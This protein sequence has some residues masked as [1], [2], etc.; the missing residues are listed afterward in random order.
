MIWRVCH[1][2]SLVALWFIFGTQ[3]QKSWAASPAAVQVIMPEW[4]PTLTRGGGGLYGELFKFILPPDKARYT[5]ETIKYDEA[6]RRLLYSNVDCAYPLTKRALEVSIQQGE[7]VDMIESMPVLISKSYLFSRPGSPLIRSVKHME[8][9]V[10]IQIA[11]ENYNH[12]FRGLD[13]QF[14]NVA[15]ASE[16]VR[17]LLAGRGDAM[18][19]SLPDILFSIADM[20]VPLPDFDPDFVVLEYENAVT[21]RESDRAAALIREFDERVRVTLADGSLRKFVI[22]QGVPAML[23]DAYLPTVNAQ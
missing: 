3:H 6:L 8:G 4:G 1:L 11:G 19:G 2:F 14:Q 15:S 7:Q 18:F 23:V 17:L 16:T 10:L 12:N 21:C 13:A 5:V 22:S 9:K 20:G